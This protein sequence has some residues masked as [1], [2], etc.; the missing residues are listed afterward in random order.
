[1]DVPLVLD[2]ILRVRGQSKDEIV[3]ELLIHATEMVNL[4]PVMMDREFDSDPVRRT[5]S[6]RI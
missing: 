2:A 6:A 1:M 3:E 5:V 4:N